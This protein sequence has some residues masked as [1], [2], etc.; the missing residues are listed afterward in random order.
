MSRTTSK[1]GRSHRTHVPPEV[2]TPRDINGTM[3]FA[4]II[5]KCVLLD[6]VSSCI[7]CNSTP[8]CWALGCIA[9]VHPPLGAWAAVELTQALGNLSFPHPMPFAGEDGGV[10]ELEAVC[11]AV[12]DAGAPVEV[13]AFHLPIGHCRGLATQDSWGKRMFKVSSASPHHTCAFVFL[14]YR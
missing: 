6:W 7:W 12:A 13:G 14:N 11:T 5:F 3:P 1:G 9:M 2:R 8:P 4:L 10:G